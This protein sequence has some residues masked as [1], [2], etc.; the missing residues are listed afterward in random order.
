MRVAVVGAGLSGLTAAYR[1]RQRGH[2]VEV[3]E[4]DRVGGRMAT[5]HVGGF[6]IDVGANL[7]LSNYSRLEALASDVGLRDTWQ[8]L[9]SGPGGIMEP[10]GLAPSPDSVI[11]L[12]RLP[13]LSM[14]HRVRL[15]SFMF[16]AWRSRDDL[17]FFDLSVGSDADDAVDAW[18]GTV[19]RC[20]EDVAARLVDPFVRT[21]HFHS[22]RRLSMKYFDALAALLARGEFTTRS[23]TGF[24]E[25]LPLAL[26][27]SLPVRVPMRVDR[28]VPDGFGAVVECGHNRTKYDAVVVA[29]TAPVASRLLV[30]PSV[31]Q[32]A[33]L[34]G[35][36]YSSTLMCSFRVPIGFAGDFEGI[37]VPFGESAIVCCCSND[38][39]KGSHDFTDCVLT[40]GLHEEAARALLGASD[41]VISTLV[42]NEW[43]RL[44]P[45]CAG[46]MT[47]L[48]VQRW[49]EAL[50][51]YGVGDLGRAKEFWVNGQ[52]DGSVWL[53]GDY[54][55]HPWLEGSVRCGEKVAAAIIDRG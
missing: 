28:V 19:L 38:K 27:A 39:C 47:P 37:W 24:M 43:A 23:F 48:Y 17:D 52:G 40:L 25:S 15:L 12:I 7:M 41:A 2:A 34:P 31:A 18:T 22:A 53:C 5:V 33:F 8:L 54:L 1:L 10:D 21:F 45:A 9:R 13:G 49:A 51:V 30:G 32:R 46:R 16:D 4:S 20:G 50:P 3:F 36:A 26:A 11:D 14:P 6:G 55:N 42:A 44:Y 35:V 29:T